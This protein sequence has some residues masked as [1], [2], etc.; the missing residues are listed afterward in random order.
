METETQGQ[1]TH[2]TDLWIAPKGLRIPD[3]IICGAMKSGTSTLHHILNQHPDVFIPD[4]E[5]FFFDIDDIL[6]HPD[7]NYFDGSDWF[8]QSIEQD[9]LLFWKWY[10]S[11]FAA[12]S[13]HQIIGEDS[14]T[15]LASELAAKRIGMQEKDIKLILV[16][17]H[18]TSRAYSQY[19]DMVR[20]KRATH[21]FE[22]TL[23]YYP[24][25]I[26]ERSLYRRQL[27]NLLRY[28]SKERIKI[29]IFEEFVQNKAK[30]LI[31]ICDFIDIDFNLL[32]EESLDTHRKKA[33]R[34]RF[35]AIQILE[36]RIFR[37]TGNLSYLS[38]LPKDLSPHIGTTT[39]VGAIV[40]KV[41]RKLN[42]SISE[43]PPDINASTKKYLDDYFKKELQ[44]INELV[45]RDVMSIWFDG[46][47]IN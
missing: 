38:R 10:S 21:N 33:R 25:S 27:M 22:D 18:P 19:W 24:H 5:V 34:P 30:L 1:M 44:G 23:R 35:T 17:R 11:K 7:F 46:A 28:V 40:E 42:P 26:I 39:S 16:L 36:N 43:R 8:T 32:P 47:V 20:T 12:A 31:D 41:S 3:F 6:Q 37:E 14:T 13:K 4:G 29:V 45:E 2:A 9:P 15:Y